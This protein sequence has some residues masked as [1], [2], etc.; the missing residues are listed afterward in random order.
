MKLNPRLV[1]AVRRRFLGWSN[2]GVTGP[3]TRWV[4]LP[5]SLSISGYFL[6]GGFPTRVLVTS[7]QMSLS[8]DFL[9]GDFH[10]EVLI[11]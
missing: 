10:T 1:Q 9:T 7:Y 6:T 8:G 11:N 3:I 4:N 2:C 5:I